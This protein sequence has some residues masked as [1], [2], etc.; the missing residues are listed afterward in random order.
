MFELT[1][2][3]LKEM[4]ECAAALRR[5][6][7]ASSSME[8]TAQRIVTYLYDNLRF[9]ETDS[10]S[11]ALLRFF[12]THPY[13]DLGPNLQEFA[14]NTLASE[15]SAETKCLTLLATAGEKQQWNSRQQS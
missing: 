8:E 7:D 3:S 6:G 1:D 14:R 12:K 10:R 4:T 15:P 11:C 13:A 2:F 9:R 5:F